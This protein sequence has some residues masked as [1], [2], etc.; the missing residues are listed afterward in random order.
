MDGGRDIKESGNIAFKAGVWYIISSILVKMISIITTPIFTR[1]LSTDEYGTVA[2]FSSWY[3]MFLVIYGLNLWTSIGRA[4]IDFPDKLDEYIGS[5]QLLSLL[6]SLIISGVIC[7]FITPLSAFFDLSRFGTILL[8]LYLIASPTINFMQ[9]GFRYKYKYK[10]NIFL[11]WY[12]A[13]STVLLSLLLIFGVAGNRAELR[14]IGLVVPSVAAFLFFTVKSLKHGYL[15]VKFGYWKYG[16]SISL[17]M[18]LHSISLN[19]L[20]QSDRVVISK[21]C[22]PTPVAYYSLVRNFALLILVVTDAMNQAWQPW[23][24]DSYHAGKTEGIKKNAK[25]LVLFV[26]Y[27]GLACIAVG[28]EVIYILGGEQYAQAVGCLPPMV[29]GVVCQCVYTHYIN[30]ELHHKKTKYASFGTVVAA[31]LNL[32]LN[33][34]FVPIFGYVAAAYTT[35]VSYYVLLILHCFITRRKLNVHLYDDRFMITSMLVT[36]IVALFVSA[37][38][39]HV[40]LRCFVILIGFVSFLWIFR[41]YISTYIQGVQGKIKKYR[42]EK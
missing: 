36:A 18:I 31:A 29:L 33:L 26:C 20:G 19:I 42:N 3:S 17:P 39:E 7:V 25:Q 40:L 12:I 10:E 2:T 1:M 32:V 6:F 22:G 34:I 14:M 38:Y 41:S 37:T 27:I 15:K 9:S 4:K 8:L 35:F 11:A 13:V 30:I 21:F 28:P 23:F 16:L 5:V 24:H